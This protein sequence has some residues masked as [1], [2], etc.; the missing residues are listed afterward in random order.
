MSGLKTTARADGD[1][2]VIRGSKQWITNGQSASAYVVW[3]QTDP[4]AGRAGVRGFIVGRDT[5]GLVPGKKETKLGIRAS[6]TVELIFEE[7]GRIFRTLLA[8]FEI[9]G[10]EQVSQLAGRCLRQ[11]R[12][13]AG[14][15]DIE[16]GELLVVSVR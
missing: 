2:F 4:S 5:P 11:L 1:Y 7:R 6:S 9:L 8:L 14:V 12:V 10:D 16:R 13:V 15:I 3:A